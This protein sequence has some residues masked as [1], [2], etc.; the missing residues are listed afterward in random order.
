MSTKAPPKTHI[1]PREKLGHY[2]NL[3]ED[4]PDDIYDKINQTTNQSW[5]EPGSANSS[6]EIDAIR[7]IFDNKRMSLQEKEAIASKMLTGDHQFPQYSRGSS[8]HEYPQDSKR[9]SRGMDRMEDKHARLNRHKMPKPQFLTLITKSAAI[10]E[11]NP[12]T[13]YR[14]KI[15]TIRNAPPNIIPIVSKSTGST[16][17]FRYKPEHDRTNAYKNLQTAEAKR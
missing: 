11:I 10:P 9:N 6:A 1:N 2:Y 12:A 5:Y 3:E 13:V 8:P 4:L 14:N 7:T 17:I 15:E 16:E